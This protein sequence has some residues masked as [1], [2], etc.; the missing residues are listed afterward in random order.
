MKNEQTEFNILLVSDIHEQKDQLEKLVKLCKATNYKPDYIISTGDHVTLSQGGKGDVEV[1]K[2]AEQTIKELIETL[3]VLCDKVIYIPGNH[4]PSTM[5]SDT[6]PSL[7]EK[8]TN[9]HKKS[10][11]L[12]SDL[13]LLGVGGSISNPYSDEKDYHKYQITDYDKIA[14]KSYPYI[15][16]VKH[17]HFKP[18]DEA[19]G[20]ALDEAFSILPQY[21]S[22]VILLTHNGP[23]TSHTAN[24]I[25]EGRTVYS[26]SMEMDKFLVNNVNK[27]IA[28][29]HGHT[30]KGKGMAK[31]FTTDIINVG[32]TAKGHYEKITI[33][34]DQSTRF[35]WRITKIDRCTMI[36]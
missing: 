26:G 9:L 34:K 14:W 28:N 2:K 7:T 5:F 33:K 24:A 29:I 1:I 36:D 35:E 22:K 27:I 31:V 30:H 3:E 25:Y 8:S 17:P 21:N 23:F 20:K 32:N 19:F 6:P 18:A 15:D 13:V 11:N 12:A 4:D 16:D 10:F